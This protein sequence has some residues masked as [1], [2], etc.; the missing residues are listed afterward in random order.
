MSSATFPTI[1]GATI[2][3]KRTPRWSTKVQKATSGKELRSAW[4][5]RP[6]YEFQVTFEFLRQGVRPGDGTYTEAATL[7]DF[8]NARKG[9]WDTFFYTD[10]HDGTTRTVRFLDDALELE[11]F[12]A[13]HW[14]SQGIKMIEVI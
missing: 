9:A 13:Y 3:V 4:Q 1:A 14:K 10:P 2:T 8:Y 5:S 12:T 11:R 6:I 7:I